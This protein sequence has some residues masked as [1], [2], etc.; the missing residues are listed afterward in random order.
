MHLEEGIIH[1]PIVAKID[2]MPAT[3]FGG[4]L[5]IGM[6]NKTGKRIAWIA[7]IDPIAIGKLAIQG[8][9]QAVRAIGLPPFI[10]SAIIG[11]QCGNVYA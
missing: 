9:N 11:G 8:E 10:F 4:R 3:V 7:R 1:G 6:L 2:E 5:I